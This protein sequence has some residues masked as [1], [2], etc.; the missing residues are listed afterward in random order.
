MTK[1]VLTVLGVFG[2]FGAQNL[3]GESAVEVKQAKAAS[4]SQIQ[5]DELDLNLYRGEVFVEAR[6]DWQDGL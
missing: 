5:S 4:D 6:V 2:F 3:A 1:F